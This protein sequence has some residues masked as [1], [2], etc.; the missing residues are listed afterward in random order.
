MKKTKGI[1]LIALVITIIIL[2]I[3]A[4]IT[5]GTLAGDN[6]LFARAKEAKIKQLKAQAKENIELA[7][8]YIEVDSTANG[9]NV[10]L[11]TLH[12]KLPSKDENIIV[13]EY[14]D[15]ESELHATYEISNKVFNY[16]IDDNFNV[17]IE[18]EAKAKEIR[19][20]KVEWNAGKAEVEIIT[21]LSDTIEYQI[22]SKEGTWTKGTEGEKTVKVTNLK[23]N[24]VIYAKLTNGTEIEELEVKDIIKPEE[25][26]ITVTDITTNSLKISGSTTDNQTGIKDYTY[27]LK[28]KDGDEIKYEN[29]T[30]TTLNVTSL[31]PGTEYTIYMIAI[32]NAGNQRKSKEQNIK[33]NE[34]QIEV[35]T[36]YIGTS[37]TE[38]DASK[39]TTDN[40]QP[41]GTPLYINFKATVEGENCTVTLKDDTSKTLPYQITKNGTY[42]FIASK[43]YGAKT[44]TKEIEVKVKKYESATG[45]VKYD[46]GEW[47]QAEIQ[48][49]KDN[50][51]YNI[52][53]EKTA[54]NA[55]GLNFTFGG[56][57][58]KG[59][60][61]NQS[62]I[63]N[64]TIITSRNQSVAPQSG[65]GTPKYEGWQ[66]LE[67][68]V[69][70]GKTYV[71]KL[72]HA[73]SPENF[74]YYYTAKNDN[75]RVEYLLSG[76]LRQTGNK[77]F[78][79]GT[80]I[81]P[82]NWDKYKDKAL[83]AKGYIQDVHAMTYDEANSASS[84]I[85]KTGSCYWLASAYTGNYYHVW[86]MP[87]DGRIIYSSGDSFGVRPVVSLT[88]GVYIASGDGTESNPYV[89]GKD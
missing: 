77:T 84:T 59:D 33:I 41:K 45:L 51:L 36:P 10:T 58:Y 29:K 80:A 35:T 44:I 37:K 25:F 55:T 2:L 18:D 89:L 1:T 64:G 24:D 47:T 43:V 68:K 23:H 32:D 19:F 81:K 16:K 71:T 8:M 82:R 57:T 15:G 28:P 14:K 38:T 48:E 39:S 61:A 4:G 20:G 46:A 52:N 31:M 74:V 53:V 34:P 5:I 11:Q 42:T 9:E 86:L 67:S 73:G 69:E 78:S 63:T 49:L 62:N 22:N 6:G 17:V 56:F 50:G 40:T 65:F 70:N 26:E 87:N 12:D 30:E 27:V 21:T 75:R 3:L 88:S 76:G 66:I 72:V 79:N 7:I 60:T 85:R 54:S 13:E 83:D